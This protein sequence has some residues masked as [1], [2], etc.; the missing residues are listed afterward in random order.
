METISN[1][2][3]IEARDQLGLGNSSSIKNVKAAF[4]RLAKDCHPDRAADKSRAEERMKQ[5]N[6]AYRILLAYCEQYPIPLDEKN[7]TAHSPESV[8]EDYV[9]QFYG[10]WF[11]K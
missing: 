2:A 5:I 4:R 1:A 10:N 7:L 6:R 8:F 11:G 3:L 9:D